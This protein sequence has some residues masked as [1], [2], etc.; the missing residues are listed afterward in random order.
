MAHTDGKGVDLAIDAAGAPATID[1]CFKNVKSGG[2]VMLYGIPS[3]D[4]K[5]ELPVVDCI[6]RQIT[7]V[8]Y[9]GNEKAWDT[10]IGLVS[11]GKISLKEMVSQTFPLSQFAK[12]VDTVE[13]DRLSVIKVVLHPWED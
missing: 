5:V 1:G 6:L 2:K 4:T 8:G 3:N 7:V 13:N 11:E 9:T 12:A 10:L